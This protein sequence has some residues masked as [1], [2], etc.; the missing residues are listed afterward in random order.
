MLAG[1]EPITQDA[2]EIAGID[3]LVSL[4]EIERASWRELIATYDTADLL[5]SIERQTPFG[6][7]ALPIWQT[8]QHVILHGMGHHTELARTLTEAGYTPNDIDF[9]TY[10]AAP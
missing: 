5:S 4:F 2:E 9:L 6:I 3:A 10:S 8:L 1:T 7:M